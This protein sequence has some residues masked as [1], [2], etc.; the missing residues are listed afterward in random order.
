MH[1]IDERR[2]HRRLQ[3]TAAAPPPA[4]CVSRAEGMRDVGMTLGGSENMSCIMHA[5]SPFPPRYTG[6]TYDR[7][8]A[9]PFVES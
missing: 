2:R 9:R 3:P 1:L 4:E 7:S 5:R 8:R 6:E